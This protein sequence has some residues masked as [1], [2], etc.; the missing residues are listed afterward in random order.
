MKEVSMFKINSVVSAKEERHCQRGGRWT[1]YHMVG[2]VKRILPKIILTGEDA[3]WLPNFPIGERM[4]R[5][6]VLYLCPICHCFKTALYW[7]AELELSKSKTRN[8]GNLCTKCTKG[9]LKGKIVRP[10]DLCDK[11]KLAVAK[12]HPKR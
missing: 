4:H 12:H 10:A 5:Y 3:K 11:C 7:E 6:E 2:V 8:L 9:V 1:P